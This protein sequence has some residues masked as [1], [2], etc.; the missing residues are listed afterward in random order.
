MVIGALAE[1]SSI[2]SI[3]RITGIH[4]D[5]IM[6]LGVKIGQGCKRVLDAKM[7]NLKCE[8]IE[9][10]EIWGFIGKKQRN[11]R[12][13]EKG[14]GDIWTYLSIDSETKLMPTFLVGDRTR[15]NSH[16]F[17]EDLA[18]RMGGRIQLSTDAMFAYTAAVENAFGANVDYAQVVKELSSPMVE[19][20]RKYSQPIV[21]A[22]SKTPIFGN[23]DLKKIC[24]S[25][26][27]RANLTLR[28][29]CKRMSRLTLAFS[30][31]RE[32]FEAAI[33]LHLVYYNFV[34][35]HGSIRMTPAMA[36]GIAESPWTINDLLNET[37]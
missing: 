5:T 4:R 3:E 1:G 2:R 23:P 13:G 10:D 15:Y 6:R 30:K 27:E 32:N 14:K 17:M 7:R 25:R 29:H 18:A 26:I 35:F 11:L 28:Q 34:K 24:T 33:A 19:G 9:V 16:V 36:A 20:K 8:H 31:K 21:T 12:P 22:I 37:I